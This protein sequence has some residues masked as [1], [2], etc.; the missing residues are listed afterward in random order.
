MNPNPAWSPVRV[1]VAGPAYCDL[2]FGGLE[3]LPRL[4]E[5]RFAGRFL[6]AA[7]GSAITAIALRRLGHPVAL[8]AVVG[9]D[10][11]GR[12]IR[13]RL[14]AEGVDVSWLH[15]APGTATPVTAVLSTGADRAFVTYLEDA[16]V[17][18]AEL[19]PALK[20]FG[21]RHLHV[22]GFPVALAEPDV[23]ATAHA[24][25]A[26]VSFDPGW[27]AQALAAARVQRVALEADVLLPNR[28]EAELL[29]ASGPDDEAPLTA[30]AA[31]ARLAAA[32]GGRTT[33]VKDGPAGAH[34]VD[35]Q[36]PT[37]ATAPAVDALDPTGAGDVFD[38]GFL[39]AWWADAP[40]AE[41]LRRGAVCGA[42]ATTAYGGATAA[43]TRAELEATP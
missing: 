41:A 39:D 17:H 14:V 21:A 42:R 12:I 15:V 33:V 1:V 9:D 26:T 43:P 31:A 3:R 18:G 27:D 8:A 25:G 7:G 24:A 40:L 38:A 29:L 22:A 10:A 4:G 32:R 37:H 35:P 11:L 20:A 6:I 23:V 13:E 2:L 5:E 28:L 36:G 16:A 34:G 30:A 19:A